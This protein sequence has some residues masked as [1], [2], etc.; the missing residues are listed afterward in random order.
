[1][2]FRIIEQARNISGISSFF[3]FH[4]KRKKSLKTHDLWAF[5]LQLEQE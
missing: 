2:N 3:I 1:M 4:F 5:E